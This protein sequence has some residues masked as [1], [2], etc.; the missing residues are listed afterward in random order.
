MQDSHL[1]QLH[2]LHQAPAALWHEQLPCTLNMGRT[3]IA[4]ATVLKIGG[5][6]APG[7]GAGAMLQERGAPVASSA[8]RV[9]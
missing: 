7:V 6:F 4:G 9:L 8:C 3:Y 2:R 5:N 1:A